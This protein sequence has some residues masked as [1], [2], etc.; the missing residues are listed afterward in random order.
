MPPGAT[1]CH[2]SGLDPSSGWSTKATSAWPNSTVW[3]LLRWQAKLENPRRGGEGTTKSK[4]ELETESQRFPC[5]Y[6]ISVPVDT[7][8]V[9]IGMSSSKDVFGSPSAPLKTRA[10]KI[11]FS[12]RSSHPVINAP[13]IPGK[14]SWLGE[15]KKLRR[16]YEQ[17][18][19][20]RTTKRSQN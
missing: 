7:E 19:N 11:S 2:W 20:K 13:H 18:L 14:I 15:V 4:P 10:C 12:V 17:G 9:L 5:L 8:V 3:S 6:R 16:K 1:K